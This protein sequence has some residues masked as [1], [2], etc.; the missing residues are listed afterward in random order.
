[1][2]ATFRKLTKQYSQAAYDKYVAQQVR[3]MTKARTKGHRDFKNWTDAQIREAAE[4]LA[5]WYDVGTIYV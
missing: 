3:A 2:E 1:M 4:S 5:R